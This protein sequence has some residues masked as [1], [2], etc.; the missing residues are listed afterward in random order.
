MLRMTRLT[1][2]AVALLAQFA[3]QPGQHSAKELAAALHLPGPAVSKV[4]KTLARNG[5]LETHRGVKGGFTL[6]R[7]PGDIS[8]AEVLRAFEGPLAMTECSSSHAGACELESC[9]S[10]SN[11]WKR[12]NHAMAEVLDEISLAEMVGAPAGGFDHLK[13]AVRSRVSPRTLRV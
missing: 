8:V 3:L 2:Y 7:R 13:E 6:A 5:L 10:V 1:D 9:C 12:I 11:S 4:L